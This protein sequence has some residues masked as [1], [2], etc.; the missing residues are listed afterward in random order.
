MLILTCHVVLTDCPQLF[1]IAICIAVSAA[2]PESYNIVPL[3]RGV[4]S[5]TVTYTSSPAF[6]YTFPIGKH[7][8]A[9]VSPIVPP[10]LYAAKTSLVA[11]DT[12]DPQYDPNPQ[13]RYSY[14]VSVPDTGDTKSHEESRNGDSVQGSYSVVESDGSIRRVDYSADAVNGFNAVVQREVGA[15]PPPP[16]PVKPLV[17]LPAA[18]VVTKITSSPQPLPSTVTYKPAPALAVKAIPHV[19]YQSVPEVTLQPIPV[20]SINTAPALAIKSAP[21]ATIK[22]APALAVH[23]VPEV[24]YQLVPAA[25]VKT[26]PAL[27]VHTVPGVPYQSVPASTIKT[28]PALAV[29]T[30]PE[31]AYQSVPAATIKTAPAPAVH[32]VPGVA[33]QSVPEF[34][35]VNSVPAVQHQPLSASAVRFA[36]PVGRPSST[37]TSFSAPYA[38]YEY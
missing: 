30:V 31:V 21:A 34:L 15:V 2:S 8:G 14:S 28:A 7:S 18:P 25:T 13:Y 3:R 24:A 33:Y 32:P 6:A 37:R 26:A 10:T 20:A 27:A 4:L 22:T 9:A 23:S 29:H 1:F 38:N 36:L 5:P 17:P 12:A 11:Q 19:T 16:A 35:A